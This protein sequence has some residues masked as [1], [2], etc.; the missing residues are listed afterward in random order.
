[1]TQLHDIQVTEL[2]G[3]NSIDA[4]L[5]S[6]P[7][8][9]Y[10][11]AGGN[12]IYY[13]FSVTAGNEP[14]E[15]GQRAFDAAQQAAT[16]QIMEVYLR[17][18]TGIEFVET[19][20]GNAAEVHFCLQ[21]I[22]D[23]TTAGICSW[24]AS[25]IPGPAGEVLNYRPRAYIYLDDDG[26]PNSVNLIPGTYAY[27]TLLHEIGHM[28]GLKH[29]H[30]AQ[31]ENPAVLP[32]IEDNTIYTLMSYEN[33]SSGIGVFGDFDLAALAWIYGGD[34]LAGELGMNSRTGGDHLITTGL[35]DI[36][37]GGSG[38]DRLQGQHGDDT[39]NG[40]A[41]E[42]TAVFRGL[43][44]D[45][46]ISTIDGR[47]RVAGPADGTDTLES[48]E[49]IAFKDR[50]LA[51]AD[52]F[53]RSAPT[54]TTL[55]ISLNAAG[56]APLGQPMLSGVT[57]AY[58]KVTIY[59]GAL[60]LG[61]AVADSDGSWSLWIQ[62]RLAHGAHTLT[63]RATDRAG[64][65]AAASA[66]VSFLVDAVA[67]AAPAVSYS[68]GAGDNQIAASGTADIDTVMQLSY[69]VHS[70][71]H[72]LAQ[73]AVSASGAWQLSSLPL[74]DGT[75]YVS[76]RSTDV[77]GNHSYAPSG[78]WFQIASAL[79][80]TGTEANDVLI[81]TSAD[82]AFYGAYGV[83]TVRYSG[84]RAEYAVEHTGFDY[85]FGTEVIK[86]QNARDGVDSLYSIERIHFADV[87]VAL[88][89]D[90]NAGMAYRLYRAAF[91]RVPDKAGVGFWIRMID[92][93]ADFI[94]VAAGFIASAE[95]TAMYGPA[96]SNYDFVARLYQHV[97]HRSP[98]GDGFDFWVQ[99]LDLGASRALVLYDFS[100]SQENK[101]QVVAEIAQGFEFLPFG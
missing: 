88:D 7:D 6:G 86:V 80:R 43:F 23:P 13:T 74:P 51:T 8:W 26:G 29:P 58:A 79:N 20:D 4:L 15:T 89:I 41:G 10:R 56:Y 35:N 22:A 82:N 66:P 76:V 39:V 59:E 68:M 57:E 83:D 49:F 45:Y 99:A 44:A 53:D 96:P 47:L 91:D 77:G 27:D 14:G 75:Y 38:N 78:Q 61:T 65:V 30:E 69:S 50:T 60:A 73:Q 87:A 85:N 1:M 37:T 62:E 3:F 40:G 25:Y 90:F 17:T 11:S 64:N 9:N 72:P 70:T 63:A 48:I 100:A 34:G 95:F 55:A 21:N 16:R 84:A 31:A 94:D 36:L 92:E 54:P 32:P 33:V 52:L 12:T 98:D 28:L 101:A 5:D 97:L 93:G 67:P 2:S 24:S 81:G 19:T 71:V 18:I 46:A 42:D